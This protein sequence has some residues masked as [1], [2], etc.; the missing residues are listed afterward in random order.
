M[1]IIS[2]VGRELGEFCGN[3]LIT[4]TSRT[5]RNLGSKLQFASH[6]DFQFDLG[7][8]MLQTI[9]DLQRAVETMRRM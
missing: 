8:E 9:C 7:I 6:V 5:G 4:S 2:A 3:K 1:H